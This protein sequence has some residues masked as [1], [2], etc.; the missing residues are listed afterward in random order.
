MVVEC[1]VGYKVQMNYDLILLVIYIY[2]EIVWVGKIEQIF[3]VEGVE[4]NVGIFLFVVS[5]CV[6]V[7]NDIIGLVKVIVDVKIDC[8]LGVYV[9]GLSVVELVQ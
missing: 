7:V 9:I 8:V 4:V 1:I 5:G 3:K 2:L 6:M